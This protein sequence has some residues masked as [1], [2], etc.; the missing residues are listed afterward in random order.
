MTNLQI[1]QKVKTPD[2]IGTIIN[3][4]CP[5]NGLYYE[6]YRTT[7]VVWYGMDNVQNGLV[8]YEY[9]YKIILELNNSRKEKIEE[10]FDDEIKK[11][12]DIIQ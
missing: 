2:G 6:E 5:F 9:N 7:C 12:S 8:A 10:I 3:I 4:N 11:D 1:F